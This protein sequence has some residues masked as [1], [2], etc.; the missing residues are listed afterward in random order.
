MAL[1]AETQAFLDLAE[2]EIAP[3]T[4]ARAAE[5]GLSLPTEALPAVIDNIALLQSQTRLFVAALGEAAG[6]APEPFQP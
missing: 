5:R 2:A 4:T 1:D 6:A 3:W